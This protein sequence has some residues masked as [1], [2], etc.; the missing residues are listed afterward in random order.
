MNDPQSVTARLTRRRFVQ[1]AG[2][3]GLGLLAGCGRLPSQAAKI[4][5]IGYVGFAAPGTVPGGQNAEALAAGLRAFG[6]TE[7]RNLTVEWRPTAGRPERVREAVAD[8]VALQVDVIVVT[9]VLAAQA[10]Q[11]ATRNIPLVIVMLSD[12]VESGFVPSLARP[13]GNTTGVGSFAVELSGK[14]LQ[15]L[16]EAIPT[17]T[18]VAVLWQSPHPGKVGQLREIQHAA[19]TLG[20]QVESLPVSEPQQ[21]TTALQTAIQA[22]ADAV[23][24]L[25]SDLTV[26]QRPAIIDLVAQAR[27]PAMYEYRD[28][29]EAGGL[30]SYGPNFLAMHERAAYY[31]DRILKGAAPADLP[32]ERPREFEFVINVKTANALGLTVPQ[33]VLLQATEII[34]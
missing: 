30:M 11:A 24:P 1:G 32:M 8:L 28:W 22:K 21:L 16:H 31:V 3:A 13:A 9:G 19:P 18:R 12:P 17:M 10:V 27:L 5:Q 14:Q 25:Q 15:L 34:Q 4:P 6:Y 26:Q 23:F 29:V 20:I 2:V 33:H 7:G